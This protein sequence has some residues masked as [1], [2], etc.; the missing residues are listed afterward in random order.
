[1]AQRKLWCA[2]G[3]LGAQEGVQV[4]AQDALDEAK[5]SH[6]GK[7]IGQVASFNKVPKLCPVHILVGG[8]NGPDTV[9]S[10]FCPTEA[11][12]HFVAQALGVAL[13]LRLRLALRIA[14]FPKGR[15]GKQAEQEQ[16]KQAR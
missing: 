11:L 1:M 12:R 6:T 3:T 5:T 14:M 2:I 9:Q 8:V 13:D 7:F 4:G 16:E 15:A 10:P